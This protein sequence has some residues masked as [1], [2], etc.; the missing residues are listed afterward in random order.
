MTARF[1]TICR[2][3]SAPRIGICIV[4]GETGSGTDARNPGTC[5]I[6][7]PVNEWLHVPTSSD[8]ST[9]W[10]DG[11]RRRSTK[12]PCSPRQSYPSGPNVSASSGFIGPAASPIPPPSSANG[13][14][15]RP[16][17]SRKVER[18]RRAISS[19]ARGAVA[20]ASPVG[21][22]T[23]D[24][25][26]PSAA[27]SE[28]SS[29]DGSGAAFVDGSQSAFHVSVSERLRPLIHHMSPMRSCGSSRTS[30]LTITATWWNGSALGTPSSSAS[31]RSPEIA[32]RP[33]APDVDRPRTVD[34]EPGISMSFV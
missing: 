12:P 2:Q 4:P 3:P 25:G 24:L 26:L 19:N 30:Q 13:S 21:W 34:V 7:K 6:R 1:A 8:S 10:F 17:R 29:G 23:V 22:R 14:S 33:C 15:S 31:T 9:T 28:A 27:T 11:V 20:S 18:W 5:T 32:M 16:R